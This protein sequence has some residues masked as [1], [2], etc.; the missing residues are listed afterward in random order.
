MYKK[1]YFLLLLLVLFALRIN[2]QTKILFVDDSADNFGNAE[3]IASAIDSLGYEYDYFNAVDSAASP[4]DLLLKKYDLVIWSTSTLGTGLQLW[5]GADEDN[6]S[7]MAYLDGGGKLWITGTDFLF[8]KYGA[9]TFTFKSGEFMYDYAGIV[10]Y[11]AQSY[12]SDGSIGLASALP[13]ANSG[14]AALKTLTWAF[15]T[16]WWVDAVTPLAA[17]KPVYLM[18]GEDGYPLSGKVCGTLNSND[19]FEVMTYFFDLSLINNF[20]NL[21]GTMA[22]VLE[23][24][25][26]TLSDISKLPLASSIGME[27]FPNPV[28]AQGKINIK[29][30]SGDREDIVVRMYDLQ[31]KILFN[32]VFDNKPDRNVLE[33]D[34]PANTLMGTYLI[35]LN[36]SGQQSSKWVIIE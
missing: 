10:S 12:G 34:I 29:L 4:G 31:G 17:T 30:A 28:N 32:R 2:A 21:K 35:N 3:L 27:V 33:V 22:P 13:A 36:Q 9:P 18:G 23:Y 14:I 6:A 24:F 15:S 25:T 20:T 8:D 7:L 11:D 19:T 26:G 16:L 1:V 5:N